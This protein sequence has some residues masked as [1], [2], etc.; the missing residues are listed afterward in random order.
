MLGG[1]VLT[2]CQGNLDVSLEGDKSADG[3]VASE[4]K[5]DVQVIE[6]K[7]TEVSLGEGGV[8]VEV[9]GGEDLE[10]ELVDVSTKEDVSEK[11]GPVVPKLLYYHG[12]E[13]PHCHAFRAFLPEV[14]KMYPGLI[15]D[16]YE[17]WHNP[18][19][20][21]R[22]QKHLKELGS[23]FRA[24]PTIVIG[25]DVLTGFNKEQ[26]LALMKEHFGEPKQ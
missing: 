23:E 19:N 26:F 20:A 9:I 6:T 18:A 3:K 13:C 15:A 17:V 16:E 5:V 8:K 7:T 25:E 11:G 24:V 12:A 21:E 2:G 22:A 1:M 4:E 14:E 10:V